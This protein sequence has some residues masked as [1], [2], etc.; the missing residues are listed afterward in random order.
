MLLTPQ[1]KYPLGKPYYW[2]QLGRVDG[3]QA[4][5]LSLDRCW[6]SDN[7]EAVSVVEGGGH[8]IERAGRE[9][10]Q[11]ALEAVSRGAIGRNRR[12]QDAF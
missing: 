5:G 1:G 7:C 12:K 2:L 4:E 11:Q 8:L 9:V 3:E 10:A 6:G